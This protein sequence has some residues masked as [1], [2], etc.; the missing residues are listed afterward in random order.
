[1]VQKNFRSLGGSLDGGDNY[2]VEY[3]YACAKR[4]EKE[5]CALAYS[6]AEQVQKSMV[7]PIFATLI[8]D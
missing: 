5:V 8:F 4:T 1:M 6:N 2:Y 7:T 3:H